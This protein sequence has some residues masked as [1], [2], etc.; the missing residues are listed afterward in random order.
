MSDPLYGDRPIDDL[1]MPHQA[2]ALVQAR[3]HLVHEHGL[4]PSSWNSLQALA[5][6]RKA[7]GLRPD[8]PPG[9]GVPYAMIGSVHAEAAR[10]EGRG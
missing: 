1:R 6:H 3:R 9:T 2:K 10:R 7:H 4:S 5:L 8:A